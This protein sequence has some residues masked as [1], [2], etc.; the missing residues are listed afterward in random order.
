MALSFSARVI[1]TAL[2]I[3]LAGA[4]A[5]CDATNSTNV[6]ATPYFTYTTDP[7]LADSIVAVAGSV[8][9]V[10]VKITHAGVAAAYL[11][12][13]WSTTGGNS[14][15]ADTAS[16]TDSLGYAFAH[17]VV[18]DSIGDNTLTL[19]TIDG[20]HTF[21]ARTIPGEASSIVRAAADS[22]TIA[23]GGAATLAV[24]VLDAHDNAVPNVSV[25][26]SAS[27]GTLAGAS[28]SSDA[29]GRAQITFTA[30]AAGAYTV[31]ATLADRA[32]VSFT[33]VSN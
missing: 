13:A 24:L 14:R 8:I 18:R 20:T 15:V 28:A 9:P 23:A 21:Y 12:I 26:W 25:Q 3:S 4:L 5:G 7:A 17:W 30:P 32:T 11:G 6:D 19:T 29:N 27:G 1:A 33:V 2:S 22:M 31:T 16:T 10:R